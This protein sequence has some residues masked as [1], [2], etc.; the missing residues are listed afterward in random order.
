MVISRR[1]FGTRAVAGVAAAAT[2]ASSV[3][4]LYEGRF[5]TAAEAA[6]RSE[7]FVRTRHPHIETL[8]YRK[9][10][11]RRV[12]CTT[13]PNRCTLANREISFCRGRINLDG[14]LYDIAYN[15]P[16]SLHFDPIE[17][18]PLYH[19]LPGTTSVAVGTAGCNLRCIYCQN[20]QISQKGPCQTDNLALDA[21]ALVGSGSERMCRAVTFTYTEPLVAYRYTIEGAEKAHETG[22][23]A[24]VSTAAYI[25]EAPLREWCRYIDAFSISLKGPDDAFY[26]RVCGARME[27]VR[28]AI[29]IIRAAGVWLE[30]ALLIVPGMNDD[31]R[32]IREMCEWICGSIGTDVPVHFLRFTPAYKVQNLPPTPVRTIATAREMGMESGL[33]YVYAGNMPA[34]VG[35]N[36]YC[37][38][39]GSP[40]IE[41]VGF[42]ILRNRIENG[43]CPDCGETIP[44]KWM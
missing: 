1:E 24:T 20:W 5:S 44:G 38:Q 37:T 8:F 30:L 10:D 25:E 32:S 13:C 6:H 29:E 23:L 17:K 3:S 34:H 4:G 40:L 9:L 36:T 28:R 42:R 19:F 2:A 11:G 33:K 26:E 16:C 39:C 41:R 35:N 27:P 14:V 18:G 31:K 12:Q 15:N 22:M 7:P 43:R 21:A